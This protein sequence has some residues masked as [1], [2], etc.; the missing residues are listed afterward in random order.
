MAAAFH[1]FACLAGDSHADGLHLRIVAGELRITLDSNVLCRL[2]GAH[3]SNA[4]TVLASTPGRP[5]HNCLS[6]TGT[7][8]RAVLAAAP[9][10]DHC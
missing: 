1:V 4:Y 6:G 8:A 2:L 10:Q 3:K 5:P 7:E 9:I